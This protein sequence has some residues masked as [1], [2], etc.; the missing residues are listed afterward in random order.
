MRNYNDSPEEFKLA[1]AAA[2]SGLSFRNIGILAMWMTGLGIPEAFQEFVV[3]ILVSGNWAEVEEDEITLKRMARAIS[4]GT[5]AD[6]SILR[7][8]ERL[9][10]TSPAFYEWQ[11][12]QKFEIIPRTVTGTK[13]ATKSTYRFPHYKLLQQLFDLPPKLTQKQIRAE[14]SKALGDL[15]LP[16]PKPRERKKRRPESVAASN[17]RTLEELVALTSSPTEAGLHLSEAWRASLGDA[18]VEEI[19]RSLSNH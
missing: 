10:K 6:R 3:A 12:Q 19:I 11:G 13:R 7:A 17:A 5:D 8:Y 14:V 2:N 18:V 15:C 16:P 4:P 1:M 9:K